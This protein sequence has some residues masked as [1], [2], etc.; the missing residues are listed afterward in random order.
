MVDSSEDRRR[1]QLTDVAAAAG[2]SLATVDRV[3]HGRAG[4]RSRTAEQVH[5][6]VRQL[7]YR[8]DP[9]ASRLARSRP[10]S[11]AVVL[12]SGS[13]SFIA[14]LSE[15]IEQLEPWLHELRLDASVDRV[16]VFSP[17]A[18]ARHLADLRGKH[19]A[20]IVVGLDHPRVRAA[21]DDL[22][23]DGTTVIT[24]VSDVPGSQR[25]HYVG[26]D[27]VA[28]GRT[29]GTLLGRF[30]GRGAGDAG[31]NRVGIVLGSHGL[32]D[33]AE[34]LFGFQQVM[35][36]EH[37]HL[38]LLLPPLE[39]HDDSALTEPLVAALL[40]EEKA[41]AGLYSI[42]A[43]NRGI[44]AALTASGRAQDVVWICHELTP[45]ARTALLEGV[46][47]A[48]IHQDAGHEVRS[49]FRLALARLNQERLL[50]DQERI[51]IGV[52]LKENLP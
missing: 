50:P 1:A 11:V 4:V 14:M 7:G 38:Q 5:A 15:Q 43:G 12:P 30:V 31:C 44:H 37:P 46:A 41:L 48:V 42:G 45:H 49:A 36:A 23:A 24:L 21:I 33:H 28:A 6:A 13:N 2:V 9:A 52:Y 40:N 25:A 34:R 20:V 39:G 32:R 27:N 10:H 19:D 17:Q 35:A 16:D 29:A 47:D 18:L 22:C 8:A 26:I 51:R 3:L